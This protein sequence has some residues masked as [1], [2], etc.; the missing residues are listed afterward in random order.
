MQTAGAFGDRMAA[1]MR[2]EQTASFVQKSFRHSAMALTELKFR[3]PNPEKNAAMALE[4]AYIVAISFQDGLCRERWLDGKALPDEAPMA[5]GS[6]AVLDL[7]RANGVRFK[8]GNHSVQFYLPRRTLRTINEEREGGRFGELQTDI[9][10]ARRDE[11]FRNLALSLLPAFARPQEVSPLFLD[12]MMLAG[13][14]HF[15]A[16]YGRVEIAAQKFRGGLAVWQQRRVKELLE[17]HLDGSIT[18]AEIAAECRMSTRHLTRAFTQSV[19][20]PPHRWLLHRRV[21]RAKELLRTSDLS[22]MEIAAAACFANQSHF[23]RVFTS[24]VGQSPGA[25]R[26]MLER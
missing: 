24:S 23:T 7:R 22:L 4:D 11:T 12:Q 21:E 19:G 16:D 18:V 14:G 15:L 20:M 5:A 17:A 13:A 8:T 10:D 26:R 2:A 6:V 3:I 25:W 9:T 1:I